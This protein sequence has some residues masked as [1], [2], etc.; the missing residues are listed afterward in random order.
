M[1]VFGRE[2]ST[3]AKVVYAAGTTKDW[4]H[5]RMRKY[6]KWVLKIILKVLECIDWVL[7]RIMRVQ[8]WWKAKHYKE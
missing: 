3:R 7:F 8:L 6:P 2:T 5:M 4:W 1:K